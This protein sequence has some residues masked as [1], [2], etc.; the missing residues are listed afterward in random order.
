[1]ETLQHSLR[2]AKKLEDQYKQ[3]RQTVGL[4]NIKEIQKQ[5][6]SLKLICILNEIKYKCNEIG[7]FMSEEMIRKIDSII[8]QS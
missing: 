1:M 3:Y 4:E 7:G 5:Q 8:E 2:A 6:A